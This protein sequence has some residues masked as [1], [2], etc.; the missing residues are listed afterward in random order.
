MM[1][2]AV[3]EAREEG[4]VS[5]NLEKLN[6]GP[7]ADE[8]TPGFGKSSWGKKWREEGKLQRKGQRKGQHTHTQTLA[9]TGSAR[10]NSAPKKEWIPDGQRKGT[11][12]RKTD[13]SAHNVEEEQNPE[14]QGLSTLE[15]NPRRQCWVLGSKKTSDK[16]QEP[17]LETPNP[18]GSS[19]GTGFL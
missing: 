10:T 2:Q 8:S 11:G 3:H 14:D 17:I 4:Q 15:V 1:M 12:W 9:V 18:P 19:S 13:P 6:V 7:K 5:R 16:P